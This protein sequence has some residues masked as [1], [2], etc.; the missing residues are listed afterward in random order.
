MPATVPELR[1]SEVR[2][3]A[4]A[5]R[6]LRV[7]G[8]TARNPSTERQSLPTSYFNSKLGPENHHAP[9]VDIFGCLVGRVV[10]P[11]HKMAPA[12]GPSPRAAVARNRA[13]QPSKSWEWVEPRRSRTEAHVV[14]QPEMADLHNPKGDM[15]KH[16]KELTLERIPSLVR[17]VA[18]ASALELVGSAE[19]PE[20]RPQQFGQSADSQ[21]GLPTPRFKV[22]I[23]I[24][25]R[26][27]AQANADGI[28]PPNS[29]RHDMRPSLD[30]HYSVRQEFPLRKPQAPQNIE[31]GRTPGSSRKQRA[32]AEAPR[33]VVDVDYQDYGAAPTLPQDESRKGVKKAIRSKLHWGRYEQVGRQKFLERAKPSLVAVAE[34]RHANPDKDYNKLIKAEIQEEGYCIKKFLRISDIAKKEKQKTMLVQER[35]LVLEAE[36]E[37]RKLAVAGKYDKELQRQ[38]ALVK[39]RRQRQIMWMAALT[40]CTGVNA[41]AVL[42]KTGR[43]KKQANT[44]TVTSTLTIQSFVRAK[45]MAK[46]Q[47]LLMQHYHELIARI[48]PFAY[49]FIVK[50]RARRKSRMTDRV[51]LFL[52]ELLKTNQ[53]KRRISYYI[54]QVRR[55]Q[56]AWQH[57]LRRERARMLV[58]SRQ[59]DRAVVLLRSKGKN[60]KLLDVRESTQ[61]RRGNAA[62][63]VAGSAVRSPARASH[64]AAGPP[65]TAQHK[66]ARP[67]RAKDVCKENKEAKTSGEE[68]RA[69][70]RKESAKQESCNKLSIDVSDPNG[71]DASAGAPAH[72]NQALTTP[73]S[74]ATSS[75][76]NAQTGNSQRGLPMASL[77]LGSAWDLKLREHNC[78]HVQMSAKQLSMLSRMVHYPVIKWQRLRHVVQG[79]RKRHIEGIHQYMRDIEQYRSFVEQKRNVEQVIIAFAPDEEGGREMAKKLLGDMI[80]TEEPKKPHL[81]AMVSGREIQGFIAEG[82]E[83][84]MHSSGQLREEAKAAEAHLRQS[85]SPELTESAGTYS[86]MA[87]LHHYKPWWIV[88]ETCWH[89]F[90]VD[91]HEGT[92]LRAGWNGPVACFSGQGLRYIADS[93]LEWKETRIE[94]KETFMGP[95]ACTATPVL[96][97]RPLSTGNTAL[98]PRAD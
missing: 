73:H 5:L 51:R 71:H 37:Q 8:A 65:E 4:E 12:R 22:P 14:L 47:R 78:L 96:L 83:R 54:H 29:A 89:T 40:H 61:K 98:P 38:Q 46:R 32:D 34:S 30:K 25:P 92:C 26:Q 20:T 93:V 36:H 33:D 58:L 63:A 13:R 97:P 70:A 17:G 15:H 57:H 45:F 76:R 35:R 56:G 11:D 90:H 53:V 69:A 42:L 41:F 68:Q 1:L 91:P 55:L 72:H 94:W 10:P 43:L 66:A 81:T 75:A 62:E 52:F 79:K 95:C 16:A 44:K 60:G 50:W 49:F 80:G 39:E 67:K 27:N 21:V 2:Q 3:T 87:T 23:P 28:L 48:R 86:A 59:W 7:A 74:A 9:P 84:L 88:H 64:S 24:P 6:S 77:Y 31:K 18:E 82:L 19:M 85:L